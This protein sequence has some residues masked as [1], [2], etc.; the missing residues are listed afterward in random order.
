MS[1]K[2]SSGVHRRRLALFLLTAIFIFMTMYVLYSG[3]NTL[4]RMEV[5]ESERDQWQRQPI[6][7]A[8]WTCEKETL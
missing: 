8:G 3:I 7:F 6:F 5:M 4:Q 2:K 1:D